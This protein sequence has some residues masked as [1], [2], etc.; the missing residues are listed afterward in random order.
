MYAYM[1]AAM[2][3]TEIPARAGA[4]SV[5]VAATNPVSHCTSRSNAFRS[6]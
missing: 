3:A 4:A 5:P 2:S 1:A 6:R